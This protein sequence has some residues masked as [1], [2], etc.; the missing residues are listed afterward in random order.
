MLWALDDV[1][2]VHS[3]ADL[4]TT[5]D[6]HHNTEHDSGNREEYGSAVTSV[7][8]ASGAKA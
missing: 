5:D 3:D 8:L 6:L 1:A 7:A 2:Y 4:G